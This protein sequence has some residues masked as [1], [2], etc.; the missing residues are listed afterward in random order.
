MIEIFCSPIGLYGT[1]CYIIKD[2]ATGLAAAAD[3]AVFDGDYE[4]LLRRADVGRLEFILL[5][6]G[7]FDHICGVK[8]LKEKY[9]GIICISEADAPCLTDEYKSY[10]AQMGYAPQEAV[11]ADRLLSDGDIIKLGETDIRVAATPGHTAGSVCFMTEK[12]I[13]SGDTLFRLSVGRTDIGGDTLTLMRS[14]RRL[15]EIGGDRKVYPGH[16]EPT[17]MPYER[18]NNRFLV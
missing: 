3:C 1:N 17:T 13:F 2:K 9:G 10:N 4:R 5:T 8:A 11:Q 14:L 18:R 15:S 6:H 12:E 7:H 16:G